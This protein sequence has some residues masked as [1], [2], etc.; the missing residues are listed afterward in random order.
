M[1]RADRLFQ[2]VQYLRGRRLT[3]AA[4]LGAWLHVSERTIYRDIRDLS[5]SGIPVLSEAGVGYRL[6]SHFEIPPIMFTFDEVE[7]LVAGA[8]AIEAWGGTS[9]ADSARSAI[10]KITQALPTAR[11]ENVERTRVYAPAFHVRREA[12][13][14][15]DPLRLAIQHHSKLKIEYEDQGNKTSSR[16]IRPL[17]LYFWGEKWTLLAYC[18]SRK[19]FRN[20]R[21]DRIRQLEDAKEIFV[22]EPG[23]TLQD[24]MEKIAR[25]ADGEARK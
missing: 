9:L 18:E 7:A 22:E 3:T 8:R 1:R 17:G 14:F 5:L 15:I 25:K 6:S 20:F 19:D 2:L 23:K 4:Q 12:F 11:R 10:A 21:L 24:F 13:A 16:K